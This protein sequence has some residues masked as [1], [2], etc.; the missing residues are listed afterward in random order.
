MTYKKN[1]LVK[2]AFILSVLFSITAGAQNQD[3]DDLFEKFNEPDS[4]EVAASEAFLVEAPK[5]TD[6]ALN[7]F[8]AGL[9]YTNQ[10][11]VGSY[12]L[13][14]A[15]LGTTSQ[16]RVKSELFHNVG[17][18]LRYS[19]LPINRVGTDLNFSYSRTVNHVNVSAAEI[20]TVKGEVNLAY[21]FDI[22]GKKSLTAYCLLG[23]GVQSVTGV[24]VQKA[25]EP[26]G[27]GGQTGV[28]FGLPLSLNIDF[29]YS[30][31]IH[32]TNQNY[33]AQVPLGTEIEN[34]ATFVTTGYSAR[35]TYNF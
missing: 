31:Y 21:T 24:E 14:N 12:K 7:G 23:G 26:T 32:K 16:E 20:T 11:Y 1:F 18:L 17:V 35:M 34:D 8:S 9:I 6:H 3:Q 25:F 22:S 33:K 2:F 29:M 4:F 5:R 10:T 19:I 27:Y 15:T 30:Y 13:K 28:G